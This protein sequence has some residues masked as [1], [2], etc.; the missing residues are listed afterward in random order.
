MLGK[1]TDKFIRSK[2]HL[3]LH[4]IITIVFISE[5]YRTGLSI[6]VLYAVIADSHLVRISSQIFN[7]CLWA[8]KRSFC[9]YHPFFAIQ[10]IK[11]LFIVCI[12]RQYYF[13][14]GNHLLQY[15]Q[16]L[17]SINKAHRLYREQKTPVI[18]YSIL[19]TI[20]TSNTTS[21]HN[22]MDVRM[23]AQLLAPC[24]QYT[25]DTRHSTQVF[26]IFCKAE[27]RR[28]G[29]IKEQLIQKFSMPHY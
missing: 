3:F 14:F 13:S 10:Y 18:I 29:C 24:M 25:D 21:A 11:Q 16:K 20:N 12:H 1:T 22:A 28:R 17:S 27:Q 8:A 15:L 19:P 2:C 26:F 9:I 7:H 4:I 23:K 6:N 5:G